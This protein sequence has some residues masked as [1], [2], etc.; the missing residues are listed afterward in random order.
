MDRRTYRW[1]EGHIDG[2]KDT[3]KNPKYCLRRKSMPPR[4]VS[5]NTLEQRIRKMVI[6]IKIHISLGIIRPVK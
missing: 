1:T 2:Q 6:I 3:I 4:L 5:E